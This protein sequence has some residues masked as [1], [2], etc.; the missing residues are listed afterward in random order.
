MKKLFVLLITIFLI[1][2]VHATNI[3]ISNAGD[4]TTLLPATTK[5]T[6]TELNVTGIIDA[7]D[8]KCM[9]DELP[10][11]TKLDISETTIQLYNGEGGTASGTIEYPANEIGRAHV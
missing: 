1:A 6:L 8:I 3:S 2:I 9:R 11:L 10:R 4:L 7:R 5:A